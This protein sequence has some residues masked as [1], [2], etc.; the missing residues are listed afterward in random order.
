MHTL[1]AMLL[2]TGVVLLLVEVLIPGFGLFGITGLVVL[3]VSI[4]IFMSVPGISGTI[5]LLIALALV[6]LAIIA[7]FLFLRR[8]RPQAL[9]LSESLSGSAAQNPDYLVGVSGITLTPLRPTGT[10]ELKEK[11]WAVVSEGEFIP[12]GAA[13][14]V[15]HVEGQRIVVKRV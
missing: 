6:V 13:I 14:K 15:I 12:K 5:A 3:A 9:I 1:A 2:F 8:K 7:L 4:G 11:R 10:A